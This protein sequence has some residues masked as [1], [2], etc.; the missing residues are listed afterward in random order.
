MKK[1]LSYELKRSLNYLL[2]LTIASIFFTIILMFIYKKNTVEA[3]TVGIGFYIVLAIVFLVNIIYFV[4]RF[5]KDLFSKSAY[6]TFTINLST[7]KIIFSKLLSGFI[8]SFLTILVYWLQFKIL[9]QIFN[10]KQNILQSFNFYVFI[11]ILIYWILS[12][13][14][15]I[16]GVSISKIKIFNRYYEFVSLVLSVVF[17]VLLMWFMRNLYRLKALMISFS[18]FSIRNLTNIN[19]VDFFM[20][21]YNVNHKAIGVNLWILL[22]SIFFIV[23]G[24]F[25]NVYL[26]EEK[27]DL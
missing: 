22:L 2:S 25:I 24:F 9:L 16:L 12:Y 4:Y 7:T 17:L 14:F 5:R 11:V 10:F 23:F 8:V 15:L 13:V 27:I 1:F 26:L 19:G 20:V 6:F 21:Y 18:N 3:F